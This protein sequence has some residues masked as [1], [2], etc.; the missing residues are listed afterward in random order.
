M[1]TRYSPCFMSNCYVQEECNQEWTEEE[2]KTF[3]YALA[4]FDEGT[5]LRWENVA[6]MIPRKTVPDVIMHYKKLEEDTCGI[7]A[8]PVPP[9]LDSSFSSE[10]AVGG[11]SDGGRRKRSAT[12]SSSEYNKRKKVLHWTEDEHK[13]FLM[14]VQECGKGAWRNIARKFVVT[15]TP[16][17]VA[18]HAQKY[19]I[20]QKLSVG[21]K[22]DNKRRSSIH[23]ITLDIMKNTTPIED[24]SLPLIKESQI[25]HSPLP[26]QMKETSI[27]NV[28]P[29]YWINCDRNND[30]PMVFNPS[31]YEMS[32]LSSQ[33]MP[34][35]QLEKTSIENVQPEWNNVGHNNNQL[36]VFNTNN[37]YEVGGAEHK[38]TSIQNNDC[39]QLM[40][41]N[42]SNDEMS[43]QYH[44]V[45]GAQDLYEIY[46]HFTCAKR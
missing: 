29:K 43:S 40:V 3:E 23:D 12:E 16:T 41:F 13:L 32:M 2:E 17:Q 21:G 34:S 28:Q 39:D 15:R 31:N 38:K 25:L 1:G 30:Q 27:Q 33:I 24:K 19:Y 10:M 20:R 42:R 22:D 8:G 46:F 37:D 44:G 36:M 7:E 11:H 6:A 14:G 4:I 26:Q 9:F 35:P 18:S 5:P 45:T